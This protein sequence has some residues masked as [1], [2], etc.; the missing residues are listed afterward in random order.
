MK[1]VTNE[2]LCL[3]HVFV[4]SINHVKLPFLGAAELYKENE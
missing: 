1:V 4:C 3:F 2:Q